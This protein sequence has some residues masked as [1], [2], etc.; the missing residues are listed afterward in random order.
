[1]KSK[2]TLC[3]GAD[4]PIKEECARYLPDLNR[5]N[6]LHFD[7]IPFN[8]KSNKCGQFVVIEPDIFQQLNLSSNYEEKRPPYPEK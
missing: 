6:T 3:E 1:M 5:L 2:P 8:H 7:P 4:C